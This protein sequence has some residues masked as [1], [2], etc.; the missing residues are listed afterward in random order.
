M[1]FISLL[2]VAFAAAVTAV[3]FDSSWPS[4]PA[5]TFNKTISCNPEFET[6]DCICPLR[7][8]RQWGQVLLTRM[9]EICGTN[10]TNEFLQVA[11]SECA[12]WSSTATFALVPSTFTVTPWPTVITTSVLGTTETITSTHEEVTTSTSKHTVTTQDTEVVQVTEVTFNDAGSATTGWE[13]ITSLLTRPTSDSILKESPT[14]TVTAEAQDDSDGTSGDADSTTSIKPG[15]ADVGSH[16]LQGLEGKRGMCSSIPPMDGRKEWMDGCHDFLAFR[17]DILGS[18]GERTGRF[19]FMDIVFRDSQIDETVLVHLDMDG[20]GGRTIM[21]VH[22]FNKAKAPSS[23]HWLRLNQTMSLGKSA[24]N[25]LLLSGFRLGDADDTV[26]QVVAPHPT[27][28]G[29]CH[30]HMHFVYKPQNLTEFQ[31]LVEGLM[32]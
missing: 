15:G 18:W 21:L 11:E 16:D 25:L 4:C 10:E 26:R 13:T 31:E 14:P 22:Q 1:H 29:S 12:P 3:D 17:C 30:M 23:N 2:L 8:Q 5:D 20:A 27:K 32:V 7:A 6:L 24:P 28:P 19:G 9:V